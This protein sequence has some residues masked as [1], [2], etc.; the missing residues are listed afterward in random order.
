M[1]IKQGIASV[2]DRKLWENAIINNGYV[3]SQTE[4]SVQIIASERTLLHMFGTA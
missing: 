3:L 4:Y 2:G 1:G